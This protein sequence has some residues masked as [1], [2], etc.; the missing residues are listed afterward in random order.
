MKRWLGCAVVSL[1]L[2]LSRAGEAQQTCRDES[3]IPSSAPVSRFSDHGDGTVTD[4]GT[5]LMWTKCAVG[6]TG[7]DCA[8]G[9]AATFS[10]LGA[11]NYAATSR[12]AGHADWRIPNIRELSS[13]IEKRCFNPAI[14]TTVFPNTPSSL[15]WSAS[16]SVGKPSYAWVVSFDKGSSVDFYHGDN[17]REDDYP[18]RLVRSGQ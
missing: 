8:Q 7:A 1:T 2:G 10:W 11:L 14:N 6:Q 9:S 12:I 18:V 16:P 17:T 15:F 3:E 5:G 4:I 13:I